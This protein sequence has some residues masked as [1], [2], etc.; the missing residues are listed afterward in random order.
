[1]SL[2]SDLVLLGEGSDLTELPADVFAEVQKNIRA[3]ANDSEQDWANAL[4]LVHKAYE[5]S[6]VHRPDPSMKAAWKQYEENIQYAVTQLGKARGMDAD[7]RMSAN[8]FHEAMGR[9][10]TYRVSSNGAKGSES[11]NTT[12]K[13]IDEIIDN[14]KQRDNELH[15]IEVNK[16]EDGRSATLL[17]SKWGIKKNYRLKIEQNSVV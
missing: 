13:S 5:V 6:G 8:M 11:W 16:A 4:H 10:P 14:I 3:G 17:F 2:L 15:D 12:A 7:W 1:M 9:T